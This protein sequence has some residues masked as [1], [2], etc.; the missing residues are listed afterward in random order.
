M[1]VGFVSENTKVSLYEAEFAAAKERIKTEKHRKRIE[2]Q[3]RKSLY[4]VLQENKGW[5]LDSFL[6]NNQ[7]LF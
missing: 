2:E 6:G 5:L 3:D 4:D 7:S 1:G